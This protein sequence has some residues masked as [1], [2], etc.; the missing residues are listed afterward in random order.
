M[1]EMRTFERMVYKAPEVNCEDYEKYPMVD[2]QDFIYMENHFCGNMDYAYLFPYVSM[3][4]DGRIYIEIYVWDCLLYPTSFKRF[5]LCNGHRLTE[6]DEQSYLQYIKEAK[7]EKLITDLGMLQSFVD[8]V[9]EKFPSWNINESIFYPPLF[10]VLMQLYFVCHRSGIREILYKAGLD[11][12]ANNIDGISGCN[13]LGSSP[14][15]IFDAHMPIKLLRLLNRPDMIHYMLADDTLE[16]CADIYK[17][18]SGYIDTDS[19]SPAQWS[20]LVTLYFDT[21]VPNRKFNRALYNRLSE[22]WDGDV[23][24]EYY[25]FLDLKKKFPRLK[26]KL[27]KPTDVSAA[28]TRL[29]YASNY[30]KYKILENRLV[31]KRT[32]NTS[33]E[34]ADD[35]YLVRMPSDGMEMCMEAIQQGNCLIN[36]IE[37]HAKAQTTIVFLR[38]RLNPDKSFVTVEISNYKIVQAYAKYNSLPDKDVLYF[39]EK[40]AAKK[41]FMFDPE[42]LIE[43]YL[44][45]VDLDGDEV[46]GLLEYLAEYRKRHEYPRF[47]YVDIPYQQLTIWD[48]MP[49]TENILE[50]NEYE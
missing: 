46:D 4:E 39:L 20:Y 35:S 15:S 18:F 42:N 14:E 10:L 43:D 36:Y 38:T 47:P 27:P 29:D 9:H 37:S 26:L 11:N 23:I 34:Y 1:F 13:I 24:M 33:Y 5:V 45:D 21:D 22:E 44:E 12:I 32:L 6:K 50:M 2:E 49:F 48:Y 28:V 7:Q 30:E 41:Q 25:K 40:Y 19:I 16:M 3:T 17:K 31:K 8:R